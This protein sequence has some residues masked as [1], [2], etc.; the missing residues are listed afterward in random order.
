MLTL[1]QGADVGTC[2]ARTVPGII[3][4][5]RDCYSRLAGLSCHLTGDLTILGM[6]S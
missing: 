1:V 6:H 3:Y 4:R 2:L 5:A